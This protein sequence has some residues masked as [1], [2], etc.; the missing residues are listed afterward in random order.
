MAA[1]GGPRPG[2]SR[3]AQYGL[4]FSFIA[5]IAGLV[6]GLALLAVSLVAPKTYAS[7]RGAALDATSPI[8]GGLREVTATVAGVF[9]GAGNYW[10]A[11]TQNA[12]LKRERE[13]MIQRIIEAKAIS[14]E[15]R[16]LKA[17]LQLRERTRD[18]IATGRIV[19]SSFSSP[20]RYAIFSAGGSDGVR[21][22][23]PVRSPKGLIGR[24]V[25]SGALASRVLLVSD[26]ASII[27]ARILRTGQPI[28]SQ[29]RGDG[30]V[31]LRPLE[32]GRN[33]F[34]RGDIVITSGT[35]GLY[36]P[37]VPIARVVRLDDDGAIALPLADPSS[38]SFA[39]VE[40]PYE[41]AAVAE[42]VSASAEAP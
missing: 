40:R 12:K 1:P 22:G 36:P 17:A 41:P 13:L 26:R 33:P 6:I 24:V 32:V 9:G 39:I 19:G 30:T 38:T 37:L 5:A 4:F 18:P 25:D 21:V 42:E 34:R 8:T 14:Q 2:W 15:N 7:V 23:M 29:G 27:P 3:R 35:G 11:A 16:E 28:I 10:D 31:D 20:R